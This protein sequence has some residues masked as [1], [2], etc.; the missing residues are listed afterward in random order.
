[1]LGRHGAGVDRSSSPAMTGG[2]LRSSAMPERAGYVTTHHAISP[3]ATGARVA[4]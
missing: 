4:Q 1:M 2:A 3:A